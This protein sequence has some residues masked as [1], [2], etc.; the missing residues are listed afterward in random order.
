MQRIVPL[1]AQT[2]SVPPPIGLAHWC[3][4][5]AVG[6]EIMEMMKIPAPNH[7]MLYQEIRMGL[8]GIHAVHDY[9][10]SQFIC[11]MNKFHNSYFVFL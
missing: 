1:R 9:V 3:W 11:I 7:N 4:M 6:G 10:R 2:S 8:L 5:S